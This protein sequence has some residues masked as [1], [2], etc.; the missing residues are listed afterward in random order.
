M[1]KNT[2]VALATSVHS[3][4]CLVHS[5]FRRTGVTLGLLLLLLL[6]RSQELMNAV[7]YVGPLNA[8]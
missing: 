2:V 7:L 8:A 5:G 1:I 4:V 3:K 6:H